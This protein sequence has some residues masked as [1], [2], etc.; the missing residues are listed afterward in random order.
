MSSRSNSV[1]S[2]SERRV[3]MWAVVLAAALA[4]LGTTVQGVWS[5]P[6]LGSYAASGPA[7]LPGVID[8]R[9]ANA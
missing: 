9:P 2:R 3:A 1:F 4:V 8:A 7:T 6:S 5:R